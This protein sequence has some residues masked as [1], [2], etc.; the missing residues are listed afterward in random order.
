MGVTA[1]PPMSKG[2]KGSA[3]RCT[4]IINAKRAL[5]A[6]SPYK[7]IGD[8]QIF[9]IFCSGV[10][11]RVYTSTFSEIPGENT[12][13]LPEPHKTEEACVAAGNCGW[14]QEQFMRCTVFFP[15]VEVDSMFYGSD[16]EDVK[17]LSLHRENAAKY[18]IE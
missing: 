18:R 10:C 11:T 5:N 7:T 6:L 15:M 13:K 2:D 4:R 8:E 9:D 14:V 3:E 17:V 16:D 12:Q 1:S